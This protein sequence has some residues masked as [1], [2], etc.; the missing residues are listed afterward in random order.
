MD[1]ALIP[2]LRPRLPDTDALIPYLRR[3]DTAR[4]YS[5]MGP[6][7]CELA[8]RLGQR[9][10][11][12]AIPVASAT[13]GLSAALLA[14]QLR[15][16][17]LCMVPSWTFAASGHAILAAGLEPWLVDVDPASGAL[18]PD[19]AQ[20]ALKRAP[21]PVSAVMP[22]APF[23]AAP[24]AAAWDGFAEST[25][26]AV[27]VDAAASFDSV[28]SARVAQ[29]VSLH[30]TKVLGAGEGGFVLCGDPDTA[31]R[32]A[33]TCNFGFAGS[34]LASLRALNAKMSEY[35]AAV[36]L[37][38]WEHWPQTRAA[39]LTLL[40]RLKAA[41]PDW[42]W[43]AGLGENHVTN[44]LVARF[45]MGADAA[46]THLARR[47]IETRRWWSMGLHRQPAFAACPRLDLSHTDHLAHL[48]L[49][50]PCHLDLS[51]AEIGRLAQ[52]M[53]EL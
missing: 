9:Y 29:V 51:E 26:L 7:A 4:T 21:G 24:A 49:G 35:H 31:S 1:H 39:H 3:I 25:G 16:G 8:A 14:Q 20:E 37:A 52:A 15:P 27:V 34:R 42:A 11:T 12:A 23:G 17:T 13:A 22:V 33:A 5:N 53:A 32:I 28:T 38:A 19:L 45:P 50:L 36:A 43:P 30:A 18:T 10:A 44:T 47:Q 40:A 41:L 6:L 2:I 46:E 48:S